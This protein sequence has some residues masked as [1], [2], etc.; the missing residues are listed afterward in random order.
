MFQNAG[1][2]LYFRFY[3][4]MMNRQDLGRRGGGGRG[5]GGEGGGGE[6]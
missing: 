6:E 2:Q 4:E 3:V 5:V 1:N